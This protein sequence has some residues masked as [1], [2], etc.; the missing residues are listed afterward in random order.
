M[1]PRVMNLLCSLP[2]EADMRG[3]I[4]LAPPH[5]SVWTPKCLHNLQS[6]YLLLLCCSGKSVRALRV[7]AEGR[8]PLGLSRCPPPP[9]PVLGPNATGTAG[10]GLPHGTWEGQGH[11]GSGERRDVDFTG[12]FSHGWFCH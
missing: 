6:R 11:S 7:L 9:S 8:S 12:E 2:R 10:N 4:S 1:S 3:V 5:P